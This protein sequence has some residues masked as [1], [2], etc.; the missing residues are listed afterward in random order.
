M[1]ATVKSSFINGEWLTKT[2]DNDALI[3]IRNP[4]NDEIVFTYAEADHN[5]INEAIQAAQ[6]AAAHELTPRTRATILSRA[7][8]LLA[9]RHEEAARLLTL[10]TGKPIR[11]ARLEVGR[12][13]SN[14]KAASE[15]AARQ[16]GFTEEQDSVDGERI[17]SM[18]V[19]EPLGVICAITPFNF[20][21]NITSLKIGPA[22]AAGN[23]VILK[24]AD[25]TPA[26][27]AFIVELMMDAGLPKGYLN[28]VYGGASVGKSLVADPRIA[29]YTFTGSVTVGEDI[30]ANSGLRPV[31]LELGSNAPNIVHHD[32]DLTTTVEALVKAAF[33]FAGQVCVSAQRIFVHQDILD[34]FLEH[35]MARVQKLQ[36]GDPMDEATEVGPLISTNAALRIERWVSEAVTQGAVALSGG[37][38][39][40]KLMPPIVLT[41]VKPDMD[42]MSKELF[43]PVVNIL[44]YQTV[45]EVIEKCNDSDFGLQA[46]VFTND[47]QTAFAIAR[48]LKIGS[49]NINQSSTA[50]P[51]SMPYGGIKN[52]GI[53]KEGSRA[54]IDY[55]SHTKV[56]TIRHKL[57]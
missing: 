18:T 3:Q 24:P 37:T 34:S 42:V 57:Y 40:G 7:S 11:D 47:L 45:N 20:P 48:G 25:A 27:G 52:S 28:L 22:L 36:L 6:A 50:R 46:G 15:E 41:Q 8:E 38:R 10:E 13:I 53:G 29:L 19:K 12:A 44:S 56:I 21:F 39:E 26:T 51:D 30:K 31:I 1:S 55:M 33:S 14:Y 16:H 43:G 49:V 17:I 35:F 9:Q 54:S 4:W 5:E 23:A 32:A 2:V